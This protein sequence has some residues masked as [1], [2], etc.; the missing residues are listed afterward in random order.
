MKRGAVLTGVVSILFGSGCG[1][2]QSVQTFPREEQVVQEATGNQPSQTTPQAAVTTA[3]AQPAV[4]SPTPIPSTTLPPQPVLAF[5]A[6]ARERTLLIQT[7]LRNLSLYTGEI[8]GKIGPL[9]T[10]AIREFQRTHNLKVDGK[11]GPLTWV[12]LS[13]YLSSASAATTEGVQ[14]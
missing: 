5:P 7:A 12:E 4:I 11:V 13:R 6:D 8:D 9:T 3:S 10:E 2:Q 1:Q 14:E